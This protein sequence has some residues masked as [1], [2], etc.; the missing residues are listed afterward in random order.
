MYVCV[1]VCMYEECADFSNLW[2]GKTRGSCRPHS[3]LKRNQIRTSRVTTY[4]HTY[5][6]TYIQ[7]IER[8]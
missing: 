5:I 1:Y 6:H 3:Q 4:I 8:P 7:S 2:P